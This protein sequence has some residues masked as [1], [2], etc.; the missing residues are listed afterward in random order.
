VVIVVRGAL[1]VAGK[2]RRTRVAVT[3]TGNMPSRPSLEAW[4]DRVDQVR[5]ADQN[6]HVA[7]ADAEQEEEECT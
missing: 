5:S 4:L 1:L 2:S 6:S 3:P 7:E